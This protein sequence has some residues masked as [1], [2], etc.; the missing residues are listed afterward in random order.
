[1]A[2]SSR[3]GIGAIK[4]R[5]SAK[6]GFSHWKMQRITAIANVFLVIWFVASAVSLAGADHA[7]VSAWLAAPLNT[8]LMVLLVASSFWHARLGLQV[9]IED[10]VHTE[11]LKIAVLIFLDL[12]MTALA[13]ACIVATLKVAL[14]S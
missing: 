8:S 3:S 10:Y 14:G 4:A 2:V 5:G 7:G 11:W 13:V 9:V 12:V 6:S 1:M